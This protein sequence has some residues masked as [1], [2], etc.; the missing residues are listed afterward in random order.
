MGAVLAVLDPPVK[1]LDA[2]QCA[3]L[4]QDT[5]KKVV[6]AFNSVPKHN[7]WTISSYPQ[8]TTVKMVLNDKGLVVAAMKDG[9]FYRLN[10]PAQSVADSVKGKTQTINQ[11][12]GCNG[13]SPCWDISEVKNKDGSLKSCQASFDIKGVTPGSLSP[14]LPACQQDME[15]CI[16]DGIG[17]CNGVMQG[18]YPGSGQAGLLVWCNTVASKCHSVSNCIVG[19]TCPAACYPECRQECLAGIGGIL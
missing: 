1:T 8:D 16:A 4:A 6:N 10:D 5:A 9:F 19:A 14:Y 13:A 11:V 18:E 12:S 17:Y 15:F 7:G 3:T 2:K